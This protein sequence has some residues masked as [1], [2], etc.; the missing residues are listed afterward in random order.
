MNRIEKHMLEYSSSTQYEQ[1]IT[2]LAFAYLHDG[3][4]PP[5]RELLQKEAYDNE[6]TRYQKELECEINGHQLVE[7]ADGDN[8]CGTLEC[9]HCGLFQSYQL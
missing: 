4:D 1:D 2:D 9:E 6:Q 8:G 7:H 3:K 5:E